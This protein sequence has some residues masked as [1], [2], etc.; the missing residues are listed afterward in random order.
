MREA[1]AEGARC[2]LPAGLVR[3]EVGA[4]QFGPD[5]LGPVADGRRAD[6]AGV[7][8]PRREQPL[9]VV[10]RHDH[11]AVGDDNPFVRGPAPGLQDV[12][13]L[14]ILR[15]PLVADQ[16]LRLDLRVLGDQPLHQCHHRI[17]G[18]GAAEQDLVAG[19][20]KLKRGAQRQLLVIVEAAHRP[21]NGDGGTID[22]GH[23]VR[24]RHPQPPE[25]D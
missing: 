20:V 1:S 19:V 24:L 5:G 2:V 6:E 10:A 3:V 18:R 23:I 25:G 8:T 14:G 13:E 4:L 21:D 15:R 17:V 11:V 22:D 7:V 9:Q 12:V 16:E